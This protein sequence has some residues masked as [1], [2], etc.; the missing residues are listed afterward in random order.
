MGWFLAAIAGQGRT[1][2]DRTTLLQRRDAFLRQA[3]DVLG[4]GG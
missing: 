2:L 1:D 3:L 4:A